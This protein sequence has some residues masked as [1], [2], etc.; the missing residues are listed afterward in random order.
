MVG[1][2]FRD[3]NYIFML[4]MDISM[5]RTY[6]FVTYMFCMCLHGQQANPVYLDFLPEG[7]GYPFEV[8][9]SNQQLR[10]HKHNQ[11]SFPEE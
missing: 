11:I 9:A 3:K 10:Y 6:Y 4:N 1:L 8:P 7:V 2:L 5:T